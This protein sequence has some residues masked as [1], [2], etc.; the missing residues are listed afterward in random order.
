LPVA[1]IIYQ[2]YIIP[3]YSWSTWYP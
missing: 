2:I 1:T 3:N